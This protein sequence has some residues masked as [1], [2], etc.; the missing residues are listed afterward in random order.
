MSSGDRKSAAKPVVSLGDGATNEPRTT[1]Q[2]EKLEAARRR[3]IADWC[4]LVGRRI[5]GE[6][7]A[8]ASPPAP[9]PSPTAACNAKPHPLDGISLSPRSREV[10]TCLLNGD[11]EK[12]IALRLRISP[13]TVHTYVKKLHQ[14][15]GVNSRG[16]LLSRFVLKG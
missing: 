13:H 11:S 4:R 2:L 1:K 8:E 10:L 16:E 7:D 14:A 5:K 3:L 15:L 9:P 12:Q 6:I